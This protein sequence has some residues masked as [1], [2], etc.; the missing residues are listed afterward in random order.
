MNTCH[1]SL[2]QQLSSC[3]VARVD[4]AVASEHFT[5]ENH[6][7][8]RQCRLYMAPSTIPGAGLGIFTGIEL[9]ANDILHG[10]G[11]VAYPIVDLN[12]HLSGSGDSGVVDPMSDY[13]WHGPELGMYVE[14]SDPDNHISGFAPGL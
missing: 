6:E 7:S 9:K 13:I 11:D 3:S 5:P 10:T 8:P 14:T 2:P 4:A 1:D 12:Y